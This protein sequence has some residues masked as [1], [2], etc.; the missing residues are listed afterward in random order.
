M[1]WRSHLEGGFCF[2]GQHRYGEREQAIAFLNAATERLR[3]SAGAGAMKSGSS[4][5]STASKGST[6]ALRRV[7]EPVLYLQMHVALLTLHG[8]DL[9]TTKAL[10]TTGQTTLES[11]ND[12]DPSV[13]AA[14]HHTSC[15]LSKA[16][17]E[18]AEFYRAG[19]LYLA[20]ISVDSLDPVTRMVRYMLYMCY[21]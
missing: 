4:A 17:Q 3:D 10:L 20:Y 8:G 19:M 2:A 14:V 16:K 9:P 11:L 1:S 18:F 6:D 21:Q 12:V 5:F 15:M 7:Q 13:S